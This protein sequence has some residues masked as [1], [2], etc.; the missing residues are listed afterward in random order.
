MPL[1]PTARIGCAHHRI[2]RGRTL[3][4]GKESKAEAAPKLRKAGTA[5]GQLDAAYEG[6][7]IGVAA[8]RIQLFYLADAHDA[9]FVDSEKSIGGQQPLEL[10]NRIVC[11]IIAIVREY[12][13]ALIAC[14]CVADVLNANE[15]YRV[16]L[17]NRQTV[18]GLE[19]AFFTGCSWRVGVLPSRGVGLL[20][21][22]RESK[23]GA[24]Q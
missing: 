11:A 19:A 9:G 2:A 18:Q 1:G 3:R 16:V 17:A 6:N 5:H 10:R 22:V 23:S 15:P 4:G 8:Q 12:D 7:G 21:P 24:R 20:D 13:H 14:N